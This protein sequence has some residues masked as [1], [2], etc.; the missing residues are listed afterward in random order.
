MSCMSYMSYT[1]MPLELSSA[2]SHVLHA[3]RVLKLCGS[4]GVARVLRG[5]GVTQHARYSLSVAH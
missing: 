4:R 1:I 2:V 3:L 5:T